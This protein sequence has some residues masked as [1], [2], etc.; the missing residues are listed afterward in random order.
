MA[1]LE[2]PFSRQFQDHQ[3]F[4]PAAHWADSSLAPGDQSRT[5]KLG[6]WGRAD[7]TAQMSAWCVSSFFN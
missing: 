5:L 2:K 3:L 6:F 4:L 1:E 7:R